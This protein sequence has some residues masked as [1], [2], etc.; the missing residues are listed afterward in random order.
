M[1]KTKQ[2]NILNLQGKLVFVKN[3]LKLFLLETCLSQ[4]PFDTFPVR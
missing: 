3:N 2:Y 1:S 4:A